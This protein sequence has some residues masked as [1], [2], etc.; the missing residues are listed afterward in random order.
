MDASVGSSTGI[1]VLEGMANGCIPVV[2]KTN[3]LSEIVGI[4]PEKYQFFIDG[5]EYIGDNEEEFFIVDYKSVSRNIQKIF[6][7]KRK[8]IK[9]FN[10]I[11][12]ICREVAEKYSKDKFF[13]KIK[14]VLK[15]L[16]NKSRILSV[17]EIL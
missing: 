3:A 6:E 8:N 14:K 16:N 10:E 4:L 2:S 7:I 17:E 12:R 15:E 1:S 5:L 13:Q 11:K 9:E